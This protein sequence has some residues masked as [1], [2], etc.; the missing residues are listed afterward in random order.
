MI[1]ISTPVETVTTTT[2][3]DRAYVIR[4]LIKRLSIHAET[5]S[6]EC[7]RGRIEELCYLLKHF[8]SDWSKDVEV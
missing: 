2:L 5:D 3:D 8:M 7:D 1:S 4:C 6:F